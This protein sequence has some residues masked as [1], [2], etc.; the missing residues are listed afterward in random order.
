MID[1][2]GTVALITGGASGIGKALAEVLTARGAKVV[3]A[4]VQADAASAVAAS[5]DGLAIA[6]DLSDPAAPAALIEKAFG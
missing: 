5:L 2:T 3:I 4:D 6:C 1:Y